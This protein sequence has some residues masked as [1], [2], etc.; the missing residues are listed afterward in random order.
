MKLAFVTGSANKLKEARE[1]LAPIVIEQLAL[2]VPELQGEPEEIARAK[3]HVAYQQARVDLFVE[4]TSLHCQALKGLPGPYVKHFIGKLGAEGL[5]QILSAFP[6]RRAV[7]RTV[8]G[9]VIRGKVGIAA[10][11]VSGTIVAPRGTSAF[12]FDPIFQPE[13]EKRTYAEMS[14]AEKNSISHRRK[15]LEMLR[16]A[17]EAHHG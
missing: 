11:E 3:V 9:F 7:A 5:W 12:G 14:A 6:E 15:A 2:E 13:G 1:I 16:Q 8:V 10:G 4:D 17:L